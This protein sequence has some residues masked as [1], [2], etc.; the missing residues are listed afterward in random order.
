MNVSLQRLE[1]S[2][3]G[4]PACQARLRPDAAELGSASMDQPSTPGERAGPPPGATIQ[5][6]DRA[7]ALMQA[8]AA[9]PRER[10]AQQLAATCGLNR[11]TAW[12]IL[13]S[14]EQH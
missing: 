5:V 8:I 13:T 11:T 10:T 6:I 4:Q 14:L 2:K 12:R 1:Q 9:A 3:Q 7:V